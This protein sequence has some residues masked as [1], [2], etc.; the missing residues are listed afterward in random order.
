L[1]AIVGGPACSDSLVRKELRT[2]RYRAGKEALAVEI[3]RDAVANAIGGRALVL[4]VDFRAM[5]RTILNSAMQP[6][7]RRGAWC[8]AACIIGL[9]AACDGCVRTHYVTARGAPDNPLQE[10]LSLSSHGGPKPT[11]RTL[12]FLRNNNLAEDLAGDPRKLLAKVEEI[13]QEEPSPEANYAAAEVAYIGGLKLQRKADAAGSR[14]MYAA[15]VVH[16][17]FY[18]MGPE[19]REGHNPY[20]PQFR[21]ACD[22]YNAALEAALRIARSDGL[23]RPGAHESIE[24]GGQQWEITVA[25]RDGLWR[26]EDFGRIEFASDYKIKNLNN[27]NHTFGLGVPLIVVRNPA[28]RSDPAQPYYAPGLA[29]PMTAF[30]RL[31][32]DDAAVSLGGGS[33]GPVGPVAS[34]IGTHHR[35]VLELYDPLSATELVVG[36]RRIPLETDLSTPL[37]YCLNDPAL[38]Q[39]QQPTLGL[40]RP[41][42]PK[43]LTGLYMLEPFQPNKIPVLM[44]HGLWSGPLTWMEMF[45]TLHGSAELRANYQFWFYTY[46]TGQPFWESA[47][48]LRR[49]LVQLRS[50]LDPQH[51]DLALDQM[52]LV[53]HSMGGLIARLQTV[54]SGNDFWRLASDKPFSELKADPGVRADL[55][56]IFFFEPN[57]SVRR[58]ITIATPHRGTNISNETTQWLGRRFIA[59]PKDM[60]QGTKDLL[61]ANPNFFP[62]GSLVNVSTS[63]DSLSPRST[64]LPVMLSAPRG[65]WVTYHNIVGRLPQRDFLGHVAG[66]GDGVVPFAS[67]HLDDVASEVVVPSDHLQ[68][69][70]HPLAILEV[71]RILLEQAAELRQN[72]YGPVRAAAR[73]QAIA[74]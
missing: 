38:Q 14:N 69:H 31:L 59:L 56:D 12:Q 61:G 68:V 62:P 27:S 55:A 46:P 29:F 1:S 30:L 72:P 71:R 70:R 5:D 47:A 51:R 64:I 28:G 48:E 37:A 57:P 60:V 52:V 74:R 41:D 9:L 20:D 44:I 65:P 66:D 73:G 21:A 8:V 18:L 23:L 33:A 63:V 26:S 43:R 40:L 25:V 2:L 53:G 15:A 19:W 34:A 49:T 11:E 50:A 54:S 3:L 13:V 36:D 39:I 24:M 4:F 22:I 58:V 10:R 67:A 17:H 32:P 35:A 7:R 16:A 6:A 45:N 42:S